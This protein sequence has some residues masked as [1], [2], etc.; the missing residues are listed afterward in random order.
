MLL[1]VFR[2]AFLVATVIGRETPKIDDERS[3]A[4][5]DIK[6]VLEV[7]DDAPEDDT[8]LEARVANLKTS[9]W[10]VSIHEGRKETANVRKQLSVQKNIPKDD[11][12]STLAGINDAPVDVE[13]DEDDEEL[14]KYLAK[15]CKKPTELRKKPLELQG[16]PLRRMSCRI[17]RRKKQYK[18][19]ISWRYWTVPYEY[20]FPYYQQF[21]QRGWRCPVGC[22]P[23]A[24]GMIFGYYDRLAPRYGYNKYLFRCINGLSGS[25]NCAAP[26]YLNSHAR[27]YITAIRREVGTFCLF[28]GGATTPWGMRRIRSFY[29]N[30]Q[31][32]NAR[33]LSYTWR[34]SWA[35]WTRTWIS[36]RARTA[37]MRG[38]PA[39]VG[40]WVRSG[41]KGKA[42]HYPVATKF[43]SRSR[44]YR[45]CWKILWGGWRCGRWKTQRQEHFFLR[46]GWGRR[47]DGWYRI[48][49]FSAFVAIK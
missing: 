38:Y 44:K 5:G 21:R 20:K 13:E 31:R 16:R 24:W 3:A 43:R 12:I 23:V 1:E 36:N 25:P 48:K 27:A 11:V 42:Q 22:G 30:R 7:K 6:Y 37:V 33:I 2:V 28:G 29:R 8:A 17:I 19:W 4:I 34:F 40:V 10:A 49:A 9:D 14:S 15:N 47:R 41:R 45:N 26:K 46:M 35:G 39:I 18:R 32:G